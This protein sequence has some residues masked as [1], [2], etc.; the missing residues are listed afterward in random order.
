M[1]IVIIGGG[2]A[3]VAAAYRVLCGG[4]T[5]TVINVGHPGSAT[6]AAAG[7]VAPVPLSPA[8]PALS[9]LRMR[10]VGEHY[11][12]LLDC[13][14]ADGITD[15]GVGQPG[16]VVIARDAAVGG[17]ALNALERRFKEAVAQ[18]GAA[19]AG[20]FAPLDAAQ[21]RAMVPWL[22]SS[23]AARGVYLSGVF[24]VD[25]RRLLRSLIGAVRRRGGRFIV[26]HGSPVVVGD[27]VTGVDVGGQVVGCD[28]VILAAGAWADS[29]QLHPL[30]RIPVRP[31]RGQLV[32]VR[33]TARTMAA[34]RRTPIVA[35]TDGDYA[36]PFPRGRIA[37]GATKEPGVTSPHATAGG[38]GQVLRQAADVVAD[39][40]S[41]RF[42]NVRVGLRPQ[43]PDGA[44]VVGAD[45][46]LEGAFHVQALGSLGLTAGPYLAALCADAALGRG[47]GEAAGFAPDRLLGTPA[48]QGAADSGR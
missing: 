13:L 2:I 24:Q 32:H 28:A 33:V 8:P 45:P 40:G 34:G 4:A 19:R 46:R 18:Y 17:N 35:T 14:A 41:A 25:G 21:L 10:A 30:L 9:R 11:P 3:G 15:P 47:V 43:S 26:G 12:A 5:A 6:M 27:R 1:H 38:I 23:P 48:P 7:V 42:I 22:A 39:L 16:Q 37:V 20:S 36:I 31:E 29:E 44:P